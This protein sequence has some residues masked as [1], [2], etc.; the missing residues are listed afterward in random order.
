[1]CSSRY[2]REEN[3]VG[4]PKYVLNR[5]THV[6]AQMHPHTITPTMRETHTHTRDRNVDGPHHETTRRKQERKANECA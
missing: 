5:K 6:D 4:P 3:V 2:G 1:M